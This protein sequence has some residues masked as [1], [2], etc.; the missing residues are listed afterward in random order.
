MV[1]GDQRAPA[2]WGEGWRRGLRRVGVGQGPRA[3]CDRFRRW[4]GKGRN[5][6]APVV[7]EAGPPPWLL[8]GL[9]P[10]AAPATR[11]RS[12]L[13]C[14]TRFQMDRMLDPDFQVLETIPSA[15]IDGFWLNRGL[16]QDVATRKP[17]RIHPPSTSSAHFL[18]SETSGQAVRTFNL[19]AAIAND[20]RAFSS[21]ND[22]RAIPIFSGL[23]WL[24]KSARSKGRDG[25]CRGGSCAC[26]W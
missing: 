2:D 15:G 12:S 5:T 21:R 7:K 19:H 3:E 22:R 17:C 23:T 8:V 4:K 10:S 14:S 20:S 25:F 18:E 11:W 9:G 16:D 13:G 1:L 26:I 24:S 6:S